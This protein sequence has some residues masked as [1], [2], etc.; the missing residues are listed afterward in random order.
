MANSIALAQTY[1]PLLDE[2]Y[3]ASSRTAILDSTKVDIVN[4][5]TV[6]VYKT[7]MDGLADYSRNNGY[8]NGDVTGTWET[9]TLTKDRGRSFQIDRMDN[10]ETINMAF[11][12]LAGEFIRTKVAPEIDAYTF[13]KLAG[14]SGILTATPA[15]IA[16]GTTDV[17]AL[18]DD[19]EREM[20]E[21][22]VPTEGR[23]LFI[24]ETAYAGLKAKITRTV[25]NDVKGINREI[26][27][28]DDMLI[29]RVPQ[30]RFYTAITLQDGKSGGQTK[31]GYVGTKSTGKPINF[32]IVHPSAVTKVAKHVLPR[33]F[34]PDQN[35]SADAWKF[36]YRIYHDT[37]VFENKVKGIYLHAGATALS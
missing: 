18:I 24:S 12:T 11:G 27:T 6:K 1:L 14:T 19:A 23:I 26:L 15:D 21:S 7:E 3:K 16:T 5:N 29:V 2:V 31:G 8:T 33:I 28:Y 37:F 17:A 34:T 4:G 10:E 30:T 22:E 36:D 25:Q 32:M 9:L 13:A 35:Q 20:N